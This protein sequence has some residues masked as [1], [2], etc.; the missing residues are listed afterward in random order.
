MVF[1]FLRYTPN[2]ELPRLL[3]GAEPT[4]VP[5]LIPLFVPAFT[6]NC[7]SSNTTLEMFIISSP[8][9]KPTVVPDAPS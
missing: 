4:A 6:K 3:V 5:E 9:K 7:K 1:E 8:L 2:T